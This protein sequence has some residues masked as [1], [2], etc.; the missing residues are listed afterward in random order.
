MMRP[1][2]FIYRASTRSTAEGRGLCESLEAGLD[3]EPVS[4][5]TL[6]AVP[7][8]PWLPYEDH[9]ISVGLYRVRAVRR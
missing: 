2:R 3:L 6:P 4:L 1:A 9:E 7:S 8:A 5:T